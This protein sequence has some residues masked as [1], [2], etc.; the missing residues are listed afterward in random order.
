MKLYTE[1]KPVDSYKSC[2]CCAVG[3]SEVYTGAMNEDGY[4]EVEVDKK[5]E[6][7]VLS[8]IIISNWRHS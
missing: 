5:S 6:D 7:T 2:S 8:K 1:I 3:F 4:L